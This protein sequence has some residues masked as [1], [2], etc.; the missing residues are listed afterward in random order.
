M[1]AWAAAGFS[2]PPIPGIEL[3]APSIRPE[4]IRATAA[5]RTSTIESSPFFVAHAGRPGRARR[6]ARRGSEAEATLY[7]TAKR[8]YDKA[9]TR[10]GGRNHVRSASYTWRAT[11]RAVTLAPQ[12]SS[13]SHG[14]QA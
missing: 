4:A 7:N 10:I 12:E 14:T 3:H 8:G 6:P 9:K 13:D 5:P 1:P 11:I 2:A